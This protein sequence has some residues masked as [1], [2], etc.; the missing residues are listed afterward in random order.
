MVCGVTDHADCREMES[1]LDCFN[2]LSH[3]RLPRQDNAAESP[4][5][6][7]YC[8]ALHRQGRGRDTSDD[9][10]GNDSGVVCTHLL[11]R[12]DLPQWTVHVRILSI[13]REFAACQQEPPI[14]ALVV[15]VLQV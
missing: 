13:P 10:S 1:T 15:R 14:V 5:L 2:N 11:D 9:A 12:C 8:P 3:F 7:T 4:P 6:H